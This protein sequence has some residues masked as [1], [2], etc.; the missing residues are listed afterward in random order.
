MAKIDRPD[1]KKLAEKQLA[2][3]NTLE[4]QKAGDEAGLLEAHKEFEVDIKALDAI[5]E[6]F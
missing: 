2:E 4:S 3:L 1:L 6:K 5:E